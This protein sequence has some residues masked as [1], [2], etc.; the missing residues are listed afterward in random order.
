MA[1]RLF[2]RMHKFNQVN[3][4]TTSTDLSENII[5]NVINGLKELLLLT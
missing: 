3:L 2:V 4:I 5:Q 1:N